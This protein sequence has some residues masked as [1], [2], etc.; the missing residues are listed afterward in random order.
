V[1][2]ESADFKLRQIIASY[3]LVHIGSA[4]VLLSVLVFPRVLR[5]ST[6][7][8]NFLLALVALQTAVVFHLLSTGDTVRSAGMNFRSI[9]L[10][11]IGNWISEGGIM[12]GVATGG[13]LICGILW[14]IEPNWHP[15]LYSVLVSAELTFSFALLRHER[16]HK[17]FHP[18]QDYLRMSGSPSI[19]T[20]EPKV[21]NFVRRDGQETIIH[22]HLITSFWFLIGYFLAYLWTLSTLVGWQLELPKVIQNLSIVLS[23]LLSIFPRQLIPVLGSV[24]GIVFPILWLYILWRLAKSLKKREVDSRG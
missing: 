18:I 17:W 11:R 12:A 20:L 23:I 8:S 7:A 15:V 24:L 9:E 22:N 5:D 1:T 13:V 3:W 6:T 10:F 21:K 16:L 19:R 14:R 4:V 2:D